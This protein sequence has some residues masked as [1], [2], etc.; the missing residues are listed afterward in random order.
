[1]YWSKLLSAA[2]VWS[3]TSRSASAR[4]GVWHARYHHDNLTLVKHHYSTT[5]IIV[6]VASV[7]LMSGDRRLQMNI[8]V[9]CRET[10]FG[11]RED[12]LNI[13]LMIGWP[14]ITVLAGSP[15]LTRG[16]VA[17]VMGEGGDGDGPFCGGPSGPQ[18]PSYSPRLRSSSSSR[19]RFISV[20]LGIEIST[21]EYWL[22]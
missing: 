4:P 7:A 6:V 17:I 13:Q 20:K 2:M 21:M 8:V 15:D 5:H 22:G 14:Q 16:G 9:I 18:T 12:Q 1:M 19:S 11:R 3:S 10:N